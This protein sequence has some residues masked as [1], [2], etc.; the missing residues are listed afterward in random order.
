MTSRLKRIQA[1]REQTGFCLAKA[2]DK[3]SQ[4]SFSE[5]ALTQAWLSELRKHPEIYDD[6]WYAPP[7]HGVISVFGK[8][9][10][11][12]VRV[13]QPSFRPESEWPRDGKFYNPDDIILAYASPID[14]DTS[15]IGDF[16]LNIYNGDDKSI[17]DHF[18]NVL[19]A[20]LYI[21]EYARVGIEF[22]ELYEFAMTHGTRQGFSNNIE[23][24]TDTAGT[25]IGHTIPLSF[26][27]DPAHGQINGARTY[28]DVKE[29]IRSSRI[30]VNG[31]EHQKIEPNMAFT[32]EPRF[33]TEKMPNTMFHLTMIFEGGEKRIC[34]G[35]QPVMEQ[36]NMGYL[37][38]FLP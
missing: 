23:S 22:C 2:F 18:E 35:F 25:N 29:I 21:A 12:F 5:N 36:M 11:G 20:T 15:L 8:S 4:K 27:S 32:I 38:R 9:V 6:G 17:R 37:A 13:N 34:H 14:R 28:D 26:E 19:R 1:L 30:F 31:A 10:D 16:G 24:T 7:P 33:S 3:I